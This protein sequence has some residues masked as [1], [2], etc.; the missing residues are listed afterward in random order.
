MKALRNAML[1]LGRGYEQHLSLLERNRMRLI[2]SLVLPMLLCSTLVYAQQSSAAKLEVACGTAKELHEVLT[3][4][5][6]TPMLQMRSRRIIG[7]KKYSFTTI[8]FVN[9]ETQTYTIAEQI[10][11]DYYCIVG[12][13]DS[14]GPVDISFTKEKPP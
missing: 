3:E 1:L 8:M 5:D 2:K 11:K 7:N 14:L 13:G 10:E 6:E 12:T 4:F 9:A